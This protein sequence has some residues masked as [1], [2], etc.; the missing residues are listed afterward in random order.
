MERCRNCGA[1]LQPE[2]RFCGNC[3]AVVNE[4]IRNN[5]MTMSRTNRSNNNARVSNTRQR[6][7][8]YFSWYEKSILKPSQVDSNNKYFGLI[9]IAISIVLAMFVFYSVVNKVFA[10]AASAINEVS[11]YYTNSTANVDVPTGFKLY[12]QLLLMVLVYYA[13]FILIGYVCKK[14]LIDQDTN[15]FDYTNQLSS[16]GN[17]LMIVQFLL[18][19]FLLIAIPSGMGSF[20]FLI[21][22]MMILSS[23]SAVAYIGSIIVVKAQ[24]NMDKIYVAVITL[25]ASNIVVAVIFMTTASS[26]ISRYTEMI[27][28]L[29]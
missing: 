14:Y 28:N 5:S 20:K 16:Y 18:L 2:V 25:L 15:I 26:M 23:I 3:G 29:L 7:S 22:F 27:K 17:S 11:R 8:S 4:G 10:G 6:S 12:F 9:S 13:V 19:V 24:I 21:F 1:I